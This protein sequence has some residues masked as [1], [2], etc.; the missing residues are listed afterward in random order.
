MQSCLRV[1]RRL[2]PLVILFCL[3]IGLSPTAD[4]QGLVAQDP[5]LTQYFS[6]K[7]YLNPAYAGYES[8][9]VVNSSLRQQWNR[10]D[11]QGSG[12]RTQIIGSSLSVPGLMS[13]FGLQYVHHVEGPGSLAWH[14]AGLAY[15]FR[16]RNCNSRLAQ[17]ELNLG[18]RM[19]MNWTGLNNSDAFLYGDQFDPVQGVVRESGAPNDLE[20]FPGDPFMDLDVGLV[21]LHPLKRL[22]ADR[23]DYI[24]IGL[25]ANHLPGRAI[26]N[27]GFVDIMPMRYTL[28]HE[29]IFR[30][31]NN[32]FVP[33]MKVEAQSATSSFLP[34]VTDRYWFWHQQIG[35]VSTVYSSI[36]KGIWFGAWYHGRFL[37]KNDPQPDQGGIDYTFNRNVHSVALAVGGELPLHDTNTKQAYQKIR[38]GIS[39]DYS[40]VG[41]T[42]DGTG[43]LEISLSLN[44][45]N[46]INGISSCPSVCPQF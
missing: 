42:N 29:W 33:M 17:P 37:P 34:G 26:G 5:F 39:Y 21:Y 35:F 45:D 11:G 19:S 16:T 43:T 3:L 7:L 20:T 14:R 9:L 6:N 23:A 27:V 15:A 4:W 10:V 31:G 1:V 8:G 13:G 46:G 38:F 2:L 44:L 41:L 28:H 18:F 32:Q 25:V 40:F 30:Q 22:P 36:D 24:R 12:Y